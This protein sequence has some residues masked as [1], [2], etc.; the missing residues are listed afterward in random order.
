MSAIEMLQQFI[1]LTVTLVDAEQLFEFVTVTVYVDGVVGLTVRW[2]FVLLS[3][4]LYVS[5]PLA[6]S[7][8]L[9]PLQMVVV[10]LMLGD[11]NALT[12]TTLLVDAEQLL[13]L[14]TVTV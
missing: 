4:H 9:V 5:P 3:S 2:A 14:V 8:V 10:P 11:G 1:G 12:V 7:V 13:E 6:V